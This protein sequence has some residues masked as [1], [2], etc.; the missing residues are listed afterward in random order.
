MFH[1]LFFHIP[2]FLIIPRSFSSRK[3]NCL[4]VFTGK[5]LAV[6]FSCL[7]LCC[8]CSLPR[9]CLFDWRCCL[10]TVTFSASSSLHS[11]QNSFPVE[12]LRATFREILQMLGIRDMFEGWCLFR[13]HKPSNS[14]SAAMVPRGQMS[15]E[16]TG[17]VAIMPQCINC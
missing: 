6:Y 10:I 17:L 5:S 13:R 8:R 9:V 7:S 12:T 4:C 2:L 11:V 16:P 15:E 3:Q 14:A 1:L